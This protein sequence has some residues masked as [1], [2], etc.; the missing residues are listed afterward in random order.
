M[1]AK[2]EP[3][4]GG[5]FFLSYLRIGL[6]QL[7]LQA[8]QLPDHVVK[9]GEI[10]V[11]HFLLGGA[12]LLGKRRIHIQVGTAPLAAPQALLGD[13][14]SQPLHGAGTELLRA[15]VGADLDVGNMLL[16]RLVLPRRPAQS[17][18]LRLYLRQLRLQLLHRILDHIA[19]RQAC[20]R[21]PVKD[22][23][24]AER[25]SVCAAR[26][27][28]SIRTDADIYIISVKDDALQDV[29][30]QLGEKPINGIVIHTAGSM[31]MDVLEGSCKHYGV[32]YP[33]QT[34]SKA[35]TVDFGRI[36]CFVEA[37]D[38]ET[39]RTVRE[40]AE[41]LS[42]HVYEM[43]SEERQWLHVAAVFACNFANCCFGMADDILRKHGLDFGV[44]L[45]LVE[46]TV[47]KLRTLKPSEAQTGP[48]RRKDMNVINKHL[49]MLKDQK[50][51]DVYR[52]MTEEIMK[53]S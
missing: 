42:D 6:F 36:P 32:L 15:A 38:E 7:G 16:Q 20:P 12:Q 39:K 17:V 40:L 23:I 4:A 51:K 1:C 49:D 22:K 19:Q 31:A 48:A 37:S 29:A 10:R 5:S 18:V 47:S 26:I 8:L 34:F 14:L 50:E 44:M 27:F 30:K 46:E 25:R 24:L 21:F 11:V 52:M 9:G 41:I 33:M 13:A 43:N 2:K 53:R 28:I 45:P 3:P 35:K